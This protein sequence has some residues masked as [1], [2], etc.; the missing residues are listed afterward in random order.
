MRKIALATV[1]VAAAA[2]LALTGCSSSRSGSDSSSASGFA[3]DS[4]IGVALP[5]KTSE[6]WV[7]AG[8]LFEDGL[9]EAGFKGDV[10]YA[11]G[12]GV[13]DQ[14]SQIQSMITNGAKVV[15]IGAVDGGQ[16]AAQAK[17]AHDAGATVIAYDRL[18]LNTNDVD[19]YV[20]YDNEKVGELQGQ[21]LLDGMKAKFPDK[22]NFNIELFSGSPDD[23]NSAV[24]F[25]GAMKVLQPK[26]DD[27]TLKVVSGQT[28][29]KQTST[30]GWL[31]ANAQTRMDNLLAK[32][33]ASTEL[34]GVLSPNDTLARAIITSVKGAGKPVP[35]VTGQ[36][37]EA[38]SVKSIMAGEQYSTINKD[39]RNLV[40]QAITM[41]KDLQ[42][43]KKPE[44]NDDKSYDNGKKV[45][46]AFLLKPVIVT[47]EN[48]AEAYAND[49]TLEPL[50]K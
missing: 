37:S 36:D 38:E 39:T 41:V 22:K 21:A 17:A 47:K 20:A 49:P 50:T 27:G 8:G 19:Y 46:P 12:S 1:A 10:Q 9:K 15:I 35:I 42:Q 34:D 18:I 14:Q 31:P 48:A 43:G 40:K 6:N 16:L 13:S 26:I 45:V 4:T 5:T 23:A 7:L 11:G 24:F 44:I 29:I 3:K 33:Y 28:E 32:N 2:A 30:Q 25:N